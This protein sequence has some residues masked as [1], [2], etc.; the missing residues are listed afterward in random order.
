MSGWS[1]PQQVDPIGGVAARTAAWTAATTAYVLGVLLSVLTASEV[2][3]PAAEIAAF[4]AFGVGCII[5]V[6]G[7]SPYRFPFGRVR[8][9]LALS[10]M[11]AAVVLD[12][13]ARWGANAEVRD[14]WPSVCMSII[15]IFTGVYRPAWEIV[16][17]LVPSCLVVMA[18]TAAQAAGGGY[19]SATVPLAGVIVAAVAPLAAAG[20]ATAAVSYGVVANFRE[21]RRTSVDERRDA[22][23]GLRSRIAPEVHAARRALL[24]AEVTPYLR[25]L[26]DSGVLTAGDSDRA[27]SL[28]A[29]LRDTMVEDSGRNWLDE[30]VDELDD[31]ERLAERMSAPQRGALRAFLTELRSTRLFAPGGFSARLRAHETEVLANVTARFADEKHRRPPRVGWYMAVLRRFFPGARVDLT[32]AE[33]VLEFDFREV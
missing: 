19:D 9:A 21:L 18:V 26:A 31:P 32:P 14:D 8:H 33:L 25:R 10:A 11:L 17:Y 6:R 13:V 3:V 1:S 28:A 2:R 7:A 22:V 24:D 20:I 23:A 27:R 29:A 4:L 5:F 16:A 15:V 30:L 12:A